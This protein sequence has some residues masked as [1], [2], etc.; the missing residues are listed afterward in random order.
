VALG[1]V[2]GV[3]LVTVDEADTPPVAAPA[4]PAVTPMPMPGHC[5]PASVEDV[6]AITAALDGDVLVDAFVTEVDGHRTIVANVETPS[7]D[8]SRP[9]GT[10]RSTRPASS[11]PSPGAPGPTRRCPTAAACRSPSA[12]WASTTG[13]TARRP[14]L[15]VAASAA[16][17]S[18]ERP[19]ALPRPAEV[20]DRLVKALHA[21]EAGPG[22]RVTTIHLGR[23]ATAGGDH[24]SLRSSSMCRHTENA[25]QEGPCRVLATSRHRMPRERSGLAPALEVAPVAWKCIHLPCGVAIQ[26]SSS[27]NIP[28]FP[29]KSIGCETPL[30]VAVVCGA[31]V[32]IDATGGVAVQTPAGRIVHDPRRVGAGMNMPLL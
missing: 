19:T 20:A 18:G 13:P 15:S 5:R 11:T 9:P 24:P 22:V 4:T 28:K 21:E 3:F 25:L 29:A 8:R 7:G 12:A 14:P 32:A 16:N 10:G 23:I 17:W 2:A 1:G 26:A 31:G 6:G 30:L 27:R